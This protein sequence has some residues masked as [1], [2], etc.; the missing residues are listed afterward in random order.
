MAMLFSQTAFGSSYF[1]QKSFG[2]IYFAKNTSGPEKKLYNHCKTKERLTKRESIERTEWAARCGY[3]SSR[4][5][6]MF[7]DEGHYPT[8]LNEQFID[9]DDFLA[10]VVNAKLIR[11]GGFNGF[12]GFNG[13]GGAETISYTVCNLVPE[14][15]EPRGACP[16]NL[17]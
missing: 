15:Y 2:P 6:D 1:A 16:V 8:F 10:P 3:I 9:S 17:R 12:N 13:F 14:D 5:A 7:I 4:E 11:V